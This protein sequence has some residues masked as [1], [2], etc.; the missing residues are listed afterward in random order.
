MVS[1]IDPETPRAARTIPVGSGP[2][3]ITVGKGPR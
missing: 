1:E 3:G 2:G